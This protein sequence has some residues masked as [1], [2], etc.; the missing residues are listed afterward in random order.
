MSAIFGI[1]NLNEKPVEQGDLLNMQSAM[2]NWGPDGKYLWHEGNAGMGQ[3]Q[4]YNTLESVNEHY[5]LIDSTGNLIFV[6]ACRIDNRDELFE[7]LEIDYSRRLSI[8]DGELIFLAYQKYGTKC[9]QML[10]GDWS[11]AVWHKKEK[12]LFLAR[13]HYG[14]T[15][16]YYTFQNNSFVFSSSLKGLKVLSG[17]S[18]QL[19]EEII[20]DILINK[21]PTSDTT[22]F[23]NIKRLRPSFYLECDTNSIKEINYN[24]IINNDLNRIYYSSFSE[25]SAAYENVLNEAVNSRLRTL[26]AVGTTLSAGIDSGVVT[27]TAAKLLSNEKIYSFTSAPLFSSNL[28]SGKRLT[29]ESFLARE[30]AAMY[31]NIQHEVF[32]CPDSSPFEGLKMSHLIHDEPVCSYN[33]SYWLNELM[34]RAKLHECKVLLIGQGGN[35]TISWRRE[36][37]FSGNK[38]NQIIRSQFRSLHSLINHV[39]R[40]EN[41]VNQAT[42]IANNNNSFWSRLGYFHGIEVRDPSMDKRVVDFCLSARFKGFKSNRRSTLAVM[43]HKLPKG[44]ISNKY[45]GLQSADLSYRIS[46][47]ILECDKI[48]KN[49][50]SSGYTFIDYKKLVDDTAAI[51]SGKALSHLESID[52]LRRFSF[53]LFVTKTYTQ[54]EN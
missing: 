2:H 10:L 25:Y 7:K 51:K 26:G 24:N 40:P 3:M 45:R 14:V 11:F 17:I 31:S 42:F 18:M 41:Q 29:D 48:L 20:L 5:P 9:P 37:N 6:A 39:N 27:A 50:D 44:V 34:L 32:T 12:E 28:V 22:V 13:D 52:F 49:Y 33:N 30:T 16:L 35:Y 1:V 46:K 19:R 43:K 36:D 21:R 4:L 54:Y 23:N 8:T 53:Y 38:L 15:S 47:N